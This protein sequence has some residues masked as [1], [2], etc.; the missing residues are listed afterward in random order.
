MAIS[1]LPEQPVV[2]ELVLLGDSTPGRRGDRVVIAESHCEI[3]LSSDE[4]LERCVAA[5]RA[6]D[7]RLAAETSGPY[8]WQR[9]WVERSSQGGGSV[10]FNVSWYDE[11]FFEEKKDVFLSPEH[12]AMYAHIGAE[13]GA[14]DVSHWRHVG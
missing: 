6:S 2:R 13:D 8:D 4:A 3:K 10:L 7:E 11:T 5:L 1:V 9:T 12:L 14:V